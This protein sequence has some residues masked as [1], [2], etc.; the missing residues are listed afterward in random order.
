LFWI[1]IFSLSADALSNAMVRKSAKKV[2]IQADMDG[3]PDEFNNTTE[4][5]N[6]KNVITTQADEATQYIDELF[7]A[8]FKRVRKRLDELLE[9]ANKRKIPPNFELIHSENELRSILKKGEDFGFSDAELEGFLFISCRKRPKDKT[10]SS[11]E[12]ENQ[13]SNW[14][15][16]IEPRGYPYNFNSIEDFEEFGNKLKQQLN[17]YGIPSNE[18]YV[19]GSSLRTNSAQDIDIAIFISNS[20]FIKIVENAKKGFTKRVNNPKAL[21]NFLTK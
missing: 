8:L 21:K 4:G 1:E 13:M 3:W 19:Q 18:V 14:K 17:E 10:I 6:T 12:L 9:K 2:K 20:D 5:V 7:E 16:V 15:T 11:I